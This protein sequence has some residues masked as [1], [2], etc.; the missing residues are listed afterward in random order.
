MIGTGKNMRE[1]IGENTTKKIEKTMIVR[2]SE[3]RIITGR[4]MLGVKDPV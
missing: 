4:T 3:T 2:T 1:I